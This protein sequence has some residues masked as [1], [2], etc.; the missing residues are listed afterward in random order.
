MLVPISDVKFHADILP[1]L[2]C[3]LSNRFM[4]I[5]DEK[6]SRI[7]R[8]YSPQDTCAFELCGGPRRPR[9]RAIFLRKIYVV[10]VDPVAIPSE[11]F[12]SELTH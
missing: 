4:D 7:T 11:Q 1:S 5:P 8:E 2:Q 9:S 6:K 12:N 10:G 3:P